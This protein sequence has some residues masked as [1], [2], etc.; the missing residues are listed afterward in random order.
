MPSRRMSIKQRAR[1][2]G[3]LGFHADL[4]RF[5]DML[6]AEEQ[7][8]AERNRWPSPPDPPAHSEEDRETLRQ[9][10]LRRSGPV[11][12]IVE[13]LN[14]ITV[15]PILHGGPVINIWEIA[16]HGA[17]H[18]SQPY[19]VALV[20]D[21]ISVVIGRLEAEP[22]LLDPPKPQPMPGPIRP[23]SQPQTLNVNVSGGTVNVAQA[24]RDAPLV[25]NPPAAPAE[26]Q[27]L[28]GELAS[29]IPELGASDEERQVFLAPVRQLQAEMKEPQPLLARVASAWS[30]VSGFAT[31]EGT[32]Q[33][34]ERVQRLFADLAPHV[35]AWIQALPKS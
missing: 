3:L 19:F 35:A 12:A 8:K 24:G 15:Q 32:W 34:W 17:P 29:A 31:I 2:N 14:G 22:F 28:L 23:A 20:A 21:K 1:I 33:G 5:R 13:R 30:L 25:I 16:L 6:Q 4:I 18:F 11:Q 27:R 10:L 9:S 26:L 7:F